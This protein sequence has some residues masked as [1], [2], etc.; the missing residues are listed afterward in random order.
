MSKHCVGAP[1]VA[2]NLFPEILFTLDELM[3]AP[4]GAIIRNPDGDLF[5]RRPHGI[6]RST[7]LP[8][9]LT[10]EHMLYYGPFA[11]ANHAELTGLELDGYRLGHLVRVLTNDY[12]VAVGKGENGVIERVDGRYLWLRFKG[13]Q[14]V[15]LLPVEV[16]PV[17]TNNIRL[18]AYV[19]VARDVFPHAPLGKGAVGV[20]IGRVPGCIE[21]TWIVRIVGESPWFVE[22]AAWQ[23]P[24]SALVLAEDRF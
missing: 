22:S 21:P 2:I 16:E 14:V 12:A 9:A 1:E 17:H 6:W 11:V 5:V 20:V 10:D 19:E 8:D 18:N 7:V 3:A 4:V 13:G 23:Y 24:E 15:P